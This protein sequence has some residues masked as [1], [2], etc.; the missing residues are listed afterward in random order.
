MPAEERRAGG[1]AGEGRPRR[2]REEEV[3]EHGGG[4]EAGEGKSKAGSVRGRLGA[5]GALWHRVV[6]CGDALRV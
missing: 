2:R 3:R 1:D 6:L 4:A 5:L